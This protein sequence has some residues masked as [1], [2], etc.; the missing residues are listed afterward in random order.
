MLRKGRKLLSA[1]DIL[2]AWVMKLVRLIMML[3]PYGVF[4]LMTNIVANSKMADI[5]KLRRLL[6]CVLYR[7]GD[8]VYRARRDFGAHRCEPNSV[9]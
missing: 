1:I 3:T 7:L 6:G 4:A 9:L 2:Q 5:F 8:Y